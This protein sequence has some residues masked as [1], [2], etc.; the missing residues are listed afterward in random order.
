MKEKQHDAVCA[1]IRR[2]TWSRGWTNAELSRRA[3]VGYR[4]VYN[5]MKEIAR[6]RDKTLERIARALQVSVADLERGDVG[7]QPTVMMAEL[8]EPNHRMVV[9]EA[10]PKFG[11][12]RS[13]AEDLP[14]LHQVIAMLAKHAGCPEAEILEFL[15]NKM[16][17]KKP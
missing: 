2:L 3:D 17:G 1:N 9:R 13:S 5:C 4:T 8:P 6:P 11:G 14:P 16:K 12:A 15:I 10:P 7:E